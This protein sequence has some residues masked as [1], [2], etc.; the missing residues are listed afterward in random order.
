MVFATGVP[1]SRPAVERVTPAGNVPVSL[2]VGA[3]NPEAFTWNESG[4]PMLNVVFAAV[5]M[6]SV[7]L[8]VNVKSWITL[9]PAPLVA[10]IV[11]S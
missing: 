4:P 6:T 5:V 3:G 7:W 10:V 9:D 11:M 1:L 8:T 2:K